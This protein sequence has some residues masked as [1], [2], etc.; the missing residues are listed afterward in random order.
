MT[1]QRERAERFRA[2]HHGDAVLVLP[3]AWD[4][5]SARAFELA[6]ARAIATT[7]AGVAA[8]F[9]YPDGQLIP[10][11]LLLL[12]VR[13]IV[14]TVAVPVSV[15][16]E[17]GYGRTPAEVCDAVR[18][19]V[20]AGAVG[21]NIED[22]R[23]PATSLVE[24]IRAIRAA[25]PGPVFVNARCDLYLNQ[26]GSPEERFAETVSR[27]EAYVAAGADGVFVPGVGDAPTIA[28]LHAAVPRPLN[29]LAG[30]GVPPVR[31]LSRLGV[32]RVSAGSG[33]MRAALTLAV[34]AVEVLLREGSYADF[35]E[36]T[37]THAEVNRMFTRS[38]G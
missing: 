5:A 25:D 1:T 9:G 36:G 26:V 37:L 35:V 19:V 11:D 28:R 20:E 13:R 4:A 6:G 31:E 17:A 12:M 27:L 32:A 7:S 38:D 29:V 16:L 33:L 3:N 34:R 10:R 23:E 8:V 21:I 14:G 24:K 30:P 22:G 15:D 2:L 18:D